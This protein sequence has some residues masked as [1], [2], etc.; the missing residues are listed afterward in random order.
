MNDHIAGEDLAAYVDG[1]LPD[2]KKAELESHFSRCSDCL[3]ALAEIVDIQSGRVKIPGEFLRRALNVPIHG[4]SGVPAEGG[5]GEKHV[6]RK[7]ALPMRLVFE[8][9]AAFL[10]VV[11]IGYFFLGGSRFWQA[12]RTPME[13]NA[14]TADKPVSSSPSEVDKTIP[15]LAG[16]ADSSPGSG[17]KKRPVEKSATA[18]PVPE[19]PSEGKPEPAAAFKDGDFSPTDEK[20][21]QE[22]EQKLEEAAAPVAQA[23][24]DKRNEA[25]SLRSRYA[26][27]TATAGTVRPALAAKVQAAPPAGK[28]KA[29]ALPATHYNE[30]GMGDEAPYRSRSAKMAAVAGAVQLFLAATGRAAAPIGIK[31]ADSGPQAYFR[32]EGEVAWADLRQPELLDDWYWFKKGMILEL[33]ID[34]AGSVTQVMTVGQWDQPVA[35]KAEKAARKLLF[36]VSENKSRRARIFVSA[37]SPN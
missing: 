10:V 7:P 5:L 26:E 2:G 3:E 34:S 14:V 23:E 11:V 33:A 1:A 28:G 6:A 13:E 22:G 24:R 31:M 19:Q 8:I 37:S 15:V 16:R 30:Y 27:T 17:A 21:I 9:A 18:A 32:I 29:D 20:F 36:S 4:A 35:D 25:E 12:G